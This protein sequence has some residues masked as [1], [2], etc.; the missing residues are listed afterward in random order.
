MSE[1]FLAKTVRMPTRDTPWLTPLAKALLEPRLNPAARMDAQLI[2][3]KESMRSLQKIVN[4]LRVGRW[5]LRPSRKGRCDV[6]EK[7]KI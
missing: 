4:R 3:K 1:Y 7:R 2:L 6:K 5:A